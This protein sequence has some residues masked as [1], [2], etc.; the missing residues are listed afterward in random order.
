MS[1]ATATTKTGTVVQVIGSTLDAEFEHL[2]ALFNAL[3]VDITDPATGASSRLVA[4][5]QQLS[6][7]HI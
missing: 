4:E 7:I 2:P 5:V 1:T 3:E 6:R